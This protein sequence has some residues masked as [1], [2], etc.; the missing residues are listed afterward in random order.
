[1]FIR[2]IRKFLKASTAV[3]T[4]TGCY[5]SLF[6]YLGTFD[7][8]D[9]KTQV[10]LIKSLGSIIMCRRQSVSDII[11]FENWWW[12]I[13]LFA[14]CLRSVSSICRKYHLRQ[15]EI[16]AG[17]QKFLAY[18]GIKPDKT[19]NF[20]GCTF[21]RSAWIGYQAPLFQELL[22][23]SCVW[24]VAPRETLNRYGELWHW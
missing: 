11:F 15:I 16:L 20:C 1:M 8:F 18:P 14:F 24:K 21:F 13:E 4:R 17:F 2:M 12:T 9:H 23:W 5:R 7:N 3:Q 22:F 6:S 19:C 10:W